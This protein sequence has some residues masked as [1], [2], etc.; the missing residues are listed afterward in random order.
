MKV[1]FVCTEN[2]CRSVMAE[3]LANHFFGPRVR[4]FSAG[5][6]PKGVHPLTREVLA[7]LG[8]ETDSLHSKSLAE[9]AD[10]EFD[11]VV[12]LC[13]PA[14]SCPVL[15]QARRR[16]HLFLP[17]PARVGEI[18]AFREVRDEILAHLRELLKK[19]EP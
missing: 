4:A 12:T 3:A 16:V 8:L 15:P 9:F 11:L 1:L 6:R 19:E 13:E 17:D 2:A 14:R 7:E 10:E 5:T 18:S